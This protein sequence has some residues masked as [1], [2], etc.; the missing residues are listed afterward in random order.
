MPDRHRHDEFIWALI[1]SLIINF[2]FVFALLT[3]RY[4]KKSPG[5]QPFVVSIAASHPALPGES[6]AIPG[7]DTIPVAIEKRA[8]EPPSTF[9]PQNKSVEPVLPARVNDEEAAISPMTAAVRTGEEIALSSFAT[10]GESAPATLSKKIPDGLSILED[11]L[12][13][14]NYTAPE[15][16]GG[17]KPP[18]PK[19]AERNGWEGTVLLNLSIDANGEVKKVEIAKSSGYELLDQQ[20]RNSVSAWRF[21]PARH[22]GITIAVTV[23]QPVIFR[24]TPP[25]KLQ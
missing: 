20:A 23:Q 6:P 12:A 7:Q 19:W 24:S 22:N 13:G 3:Q 1:F 16:L 25:G 21:K 4:V 14:D 9:R 5:F 18:Y 11:K 8:P 15:Y 17:E 10:A 2:L